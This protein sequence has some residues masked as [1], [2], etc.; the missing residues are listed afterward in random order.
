VSFK[1][2]P[3]LA[4]ALLGLARRGVTVICLA[5]SAGTVPVPGTERDGGEDVSLL[6]SDAI[7]KLDKRLDAAA[8]GGGEVIASTLALKAVEGSVVAEVVGGPGGWPWLQVGYPQTRGRLIVC[9]FAVIARWQASPTPRYLFA[10]LI[11]P[12]LPAE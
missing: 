4:D 5:P 11:E 3:G 2:E 8:W 1:D 7:T 10:K 9:G 12:A 6:R